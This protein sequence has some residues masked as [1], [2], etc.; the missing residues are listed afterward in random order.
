MSMGGLVTAASST[1]STQLGFGPDTVVTWM[2][3]YIGEP[4]LGG[5]LLVLQ[6]LIPVLVT[7]G[8][9]SVV[10]FIGYRLWH[11]WRGH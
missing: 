10:V 1:F 3:T 2:W 8:I 6:E 11:M 4:I 7:I 9:V 5:G